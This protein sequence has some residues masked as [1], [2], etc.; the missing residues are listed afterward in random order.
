M[1]KQAV[2]LINNEKRENFQNSKVL[3]GNAKQACCLLCFSTKVNNSQLILHF[4]YVMC[5]VWFCDTNK[6]FSYDLKMK[7]CLIKGNQF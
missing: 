4:E 7:S 2:R 6:I 3:L 1:L 5:N